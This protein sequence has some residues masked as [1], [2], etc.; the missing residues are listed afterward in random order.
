MGKKVK[1]QRITRSV[2]VAV[3]MVEEF[4]RRE[5]GAFTEM[6]HLD[7]EGEKDFNDAQCVLKIETY[8]TH[9]KGGSPLSFVC[10]LQKDDNNRWAP[11]VCAMSDNDGEKKE[12]FFAPLRRLLIPYGASTRPNL[13]FPWPHKF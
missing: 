4:I 5:F 2:I 8:L 13:E 3:G 7:V 6:S 1:K 11:S 9:I 12:L 10:T